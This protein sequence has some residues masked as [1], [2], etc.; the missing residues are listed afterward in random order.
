MTIIT[1]DSLSCNFSLS[2]SWKFDFG[3]RDVNNDFCLCGLRPM[4]LIWLRKILFHNK[5]SQ[6][7]WKVDHPWDF[8]RN[9]N[10][11]SDKLSF[12]NWVQCTLYRTSV[13]LCIMYHIHSRF[14]KLL[15]GSLKV[16]NADLVTIWC[17]EP[18][19]DLKKKK[20]KPIN[21]NWKITEC[22]LLISIKN[23]FTLTGS[24]WSMVINLHC[25]RCG[26]EKSTSNAFGTWNVHFYP[27]HIDFG[28]KT[29]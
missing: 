8:L 11:R 25:T 18:N 10:T 4:H 27:F 6:M 2:A 12:I 3:H 9:S 29:N 19:S 5:Y 17:R 24:Q 16:L 14:P 13:Y 28:L 22:S 26:S 20:E 7:S 15:Y 1:E 23:I 21:H